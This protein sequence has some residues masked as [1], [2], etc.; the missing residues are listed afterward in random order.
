MSSRATSE[1]GGEEKEGDHAGCNDD[2]F[3]LNVTARMEFRGCGPAG[4]CSDF[5]DCDSIPRNPKLNL[6]VGYG[7]VHYNV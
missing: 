2:K 1:V 7:Y 5:E 3:V 4:L 6:Q